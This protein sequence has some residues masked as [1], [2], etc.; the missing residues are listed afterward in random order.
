M[1]NI[2]QRRDDCNMDGSGF[3]S[4]VNYECSRG[5]GSFTN[6]SNCYVESIENS[7]GFAECMIPIRPRSSYRGG[8]GEDHSEISIIS[9]VSLICTIRIIYI[10]KS[11]K[12]HKGAGDDD[13][14]LNQLMVSDRDHHLV[15]SSS[16]KSSV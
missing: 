2:S 16:N 11:S 10:V 14:S 4:G 7:E 5:V 13:C 8:Q 12:L 3:G 9:L 1:T 15:R 6:N